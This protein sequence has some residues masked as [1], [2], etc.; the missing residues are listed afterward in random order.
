MN[1]K[2]ASLFHH[3]EALYVVIHDMPRPPVSLLSMIEGQWAV[4]QVWVYQKITFK[5]WCVSV[6]LPISKCNCLDIKDTY[7]QLFKQKLGM[8]TALK[9]TPASRVQMWTRR[10]VRHQRSPPPVSS[11]VGYTAPTCQSHIYSIIQQMD[12]ACPCE[13]LKLISNQ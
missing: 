13:L 6:F 1:E 7:S 8:A 12:K 9:R 5:Q 3:F 10:P 4:R 2:T 11:R